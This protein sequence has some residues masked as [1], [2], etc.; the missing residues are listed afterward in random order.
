MAVSIA[1]TFYRAYMGSLPPAPLLTAEPVPFPL[2]VIL[3]QSIYRDRIHPHKANSFQLFAVLL[4]VSATLA[5]LF[6]V[7]SLL[8]FAT[9]SVGHPLFLAFY[10]AFHRPLWATSLLSFLYLAHHGSFASAMATARDG[11]L[12]PSRRCALPCRC[13][14]REY[15]I[16]LTSTLHLERISLRNAQFATDSEGF[17]LEVN[18]WKMKTDATD[19][20]DRPAYEDPCHTTWL[21]T[22]ERF[23]NSATAS[24]G[25]DAHSQSPT[26]V[27][28]WIHA[29]LTWRIF[30]PLS[31]LTWIALVVAEPIILYF[32]SSLNRPSYATNWS[33]VIIY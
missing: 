11:H 8:P 6:V 26:S 27:E 28:K 14:G 12:E 25:V 20:C 30:S 3:L 19:P 29:I 5:A 18:V 2:P 21:M 7:F 33:T 4:A 10:A 13:S 15:T 31:K 24:A 16:G 32:F 9:S 17:D 23:R 22:L 1:V